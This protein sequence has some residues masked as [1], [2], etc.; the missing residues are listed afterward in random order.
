MGRQILV[1]DDEENIRLLY[2][3][4]LLK[5]GYK[6]IEAGNGIE[7]FEAMKKTPVDLI[8]LD[9]RMPDMDGL[10]FISV[11][12]KTNREIPVILCTAYGQHKQELASW[13]AER[14]IIKSSDLSDL[15]KNVKE[16]LPLS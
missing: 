15:M 5:A 13:A 7:G 2:K 6:V 3:D 8:I 1:I 11:L 10:E 12:R 4:E 14:Y 9:I 16:L